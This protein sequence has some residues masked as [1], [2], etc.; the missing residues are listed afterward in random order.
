[1]AIEIA[2]MP[3]SQGVSFLCDE[4]NE[5]SNISNTDLS[6]KTIF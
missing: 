5:V 6:K 4:D 3:L 1:L 2:A